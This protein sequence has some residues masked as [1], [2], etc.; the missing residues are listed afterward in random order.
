M[1]ITLLNFSWCSCL[2]WYRAKI[3]SIGP[4]GEYDVFFV[5]YGD[6]QWITRDRIAPIRPEYLQVRVLL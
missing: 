6:R 5:D 1:V 4:E 3:L 2:R